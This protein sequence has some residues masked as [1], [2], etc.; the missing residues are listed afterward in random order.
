MIQQ[1]IHDDVVT[2]LQINFP[3]IILHGGAY[4]VE[5]ISKDGDVSLLLSGTCSGCGISEQTIESIHNR[6]SDIDSVE[7]ISIEIV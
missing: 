1:E 2:F 5:H 7:S 4:E 3:Q 6:I